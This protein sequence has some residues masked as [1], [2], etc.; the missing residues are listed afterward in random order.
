MLGEISEVLGVECRKRQ[1]IDQAASG[2]PGVVVRSGPSTSLR[3]GLKL[4]PFLRDRFVV[5]QDTDALAPSGQ[6]R[7]TA[8]PP[9]A[10][11]APLHQLP[12]CDESDAHRVVRQRC[13]QPVGQAV[14]QA[15]GRDVGV[16]DYQAHGMLA[17]REA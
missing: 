6:F 9:T 12:D 5:F 10:Q 17:R 13:P 11:H 16:Q 3:T 8:R 14:A 4:S 7:G 15:G 2:H 1:I